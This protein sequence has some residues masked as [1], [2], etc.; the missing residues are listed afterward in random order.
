MKGRGFGKSDRAWWGGVSEI[1]EVRLSSSPAENRKLR[2]LMGLKQPQI[3]VLKD[4]NLA[5]LTL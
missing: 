1:G 4:L 3:K 2:H 5:S